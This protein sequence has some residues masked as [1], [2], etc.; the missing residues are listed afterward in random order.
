MKQDISLQN[1]KTQ[2]LKGW[3]G[4]LTQ[5]DEALGRKQKEEPI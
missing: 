2:Q 4:R 5:Y 1:Q 3:A